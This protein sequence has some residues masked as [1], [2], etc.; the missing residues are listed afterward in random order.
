MLGDF[1][2]YWVAMIA[3]IDIKNFD[4]FPVQLKEALND[5]AMSEL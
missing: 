4:S 2:A 5:N 1:L 3:M